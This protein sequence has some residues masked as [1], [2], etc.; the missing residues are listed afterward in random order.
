MYNAVIDI[1]QMQDE[2]KRTWDV[3]R[4]EEECAD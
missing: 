1:T 3:L 4:I 2:L